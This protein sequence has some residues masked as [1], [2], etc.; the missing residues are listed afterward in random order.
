VESLLAAGF[1]LGPST[2]PRREVYRV[3]ARLETACHGACLT[4]DGLKPLRRGCA[5]ASRSCRSLRAN[6]RETVGP[7]EFSEQGGEAKRA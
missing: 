1:A 3:S 5:P 4:S 2:V 6:I 7:L